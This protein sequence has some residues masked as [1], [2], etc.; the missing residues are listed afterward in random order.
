MKNR[1][2]LAA[3]G[4]LLLA[5]LTGC[6]SAGQKPATAVAQAAAG[7]TETLKTAQ[8]LAITLA[9]EPLKVGPNRLLVTLD[10]KDAKATEAQVI[11]GSMGHGVVVDLTRVAPGRYEASAD[12]NMEGKWLVRVKATLP[13]GEETDALFQFTVK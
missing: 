2:A 7:Y 11:M 6:T 9:T 3:V 1:F 10:Q 12:M 4:L 13:S 5:A 8:G